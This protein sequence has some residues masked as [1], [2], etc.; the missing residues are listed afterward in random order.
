MTT[1]PELQR[2]RGRCK[3]ILDTTFCQL[4]CVFPPQSDVVDFVEDAVRAEAFNAGERAGTLF[5][6]G[7]YT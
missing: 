1:W 7:S 6:F 5:I 4:H 3:L 2:V